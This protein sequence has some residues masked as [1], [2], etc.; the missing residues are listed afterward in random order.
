[1]N[2][3]YGYVRL[4][5]RDSSF[6][7]PDMQAA[8]ITAYC[9]NNN[10]KLVDIF[11]D[12]GKSGANFN[13][14]EFQKF[15]AAIRQNK[16]AGYLIV[17][18]LDRFSRAEL[19]PALLK[20]QEIEEGCGVKVLTTADRIDQDTKDSGWI[21]L[22][23]VTLMKANQEHKDI[24]RRVTDGMYGSMLS[25]RFCN[26]APVGYINSTEIV[27]K[28]KRPILIIDPILAPYVKKAFEL[29][30]SG[31]TMEQIRAALPQLKLKGNSAVRWLLENPVYAGMVKVP[32]Y[33]GTNP[34]YKGNPPMLVEGIHEA[35]VTQQQYYQAQKKLTRKVQSH[36]AEPLWLKGVIR[37]R[38][39]GALMTTSNP[40]G[41]KKSYLYY[42]CNK[43]RQNFPVDKLH[44]HFLELLG[45][46][47][48]PPEAIEKIRQRIYKAIEQQQ[49]KKGGNIMRLKLERDKVE[50]KLAGVQRNYLLSQ[51]VNES[52]YT[53]IVT[54]L[55]GTISDIDLQLERASTDTAKMQAVVEKLL[56]MMTDLSSVF[57]R[58]PLYQKHQFLH[59]LFPSGVWWYDNAARTTTI[60]PLFNDKLL[61]LKEKGLL[62]LEQPSFFFSNSDVVIP[63]GLEPRAHTLKVYCSTN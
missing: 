48:R 19:L 2:E 13:R 8:G 25:G 18:N 49:E 11:F 28:K 56:P 30:L 55:N 31:A 32:A 10:I 35:I 43:H 59:L 44:A 27:R 63:L 50:K 37:C 6:N 53:E 21:L 33:K 36:P 54:E 47:S 39:C 34:E 15:E 42:I 46:L 9:R 52:V 45:S 62:F 61:T 57:L 51:N 16:K 1:M 38:E 26:K 14:P 58:M 40:T 41:R 23:I 3:A 7:S 17:S 60:Y 24:V 5:D 22:R 12:N 29:F 4:S 20:L